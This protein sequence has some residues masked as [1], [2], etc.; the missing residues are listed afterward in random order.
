MSCFLRW[1]YNSTRFA[2]C[3][4]FYEKIFYFFQIFF[5]FIKIA[6]RLPLFARLFAPNRSPLPPHK[7]ERRVRFRSVEPKFCRGPLKALQPLGLQAAFRPK[8]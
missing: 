8:K 3:Q 2:V 1:P 7:H 4:R 6:E 5:G